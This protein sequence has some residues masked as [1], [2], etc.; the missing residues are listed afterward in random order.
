MRHGLWS[1]FSRDGLCRESLSRLKPFN[2]IPIFALLR[3]A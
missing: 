3:G 1:G 2:R